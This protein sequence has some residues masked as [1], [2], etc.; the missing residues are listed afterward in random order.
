MSK[1]NA[2]RIINLNYNNNAICISDETFQ[3]GGQSTLLSLRNGG[4][5]SVLVQMMTAPFVHKQYRKTKDRPFESYFTT[6]KPTFILVEWA[7]DQGAG[8]CL[9]GMMVRKSQVSEEQ[10]AEP[11]EI[12]NFISE[13]SSRCEQDIYNLPVVEKSKKEIVLK[14]FAVCKQL[15]E[16]YKRDNSVKFYYYDMNNYAQSRQ[17]FDKLTEYRIYYKEWENIIKKI[18][19][20]E[21]GLSELFVDCK[22][23]KDLVAEWFLPAV[24]SKL[25]LERNRIKEFQNII[26]K[27]VTMYKDNKSKIE[28]RDT[29]LKFK[30]DMIGVEEHALSYQEKEKSVHGMENRIACFTK[31]LY[32]L[33]ELVRQD[34]QGIEEKK[35]ECEEKI[36][37]L[38]YEKLSMEVHVLEEELKKRNSNRNLLG[39]ERDSLEEELAKIEH[40]IHLFECARQQEI[41]EECRK[42][43][44]LLTEKAEVLKQSEEELEPERRKIGGTLKQYYR[45]QL[46]ENHKTEAAV[47]EQRQDEEKKLSVQRQNEAAYA[48]RLEELLVALTEC[49]VM[50][51][52]FNEKEE[53]YNK[54]YREGLTRNVV[55]DYEAG[56]LEIKKA[57]YQKQQE[58][59]NRSCTSNI[60]RHKEAEEQK[61]GCDRT[62]EDKRD[63]LLSQAYA[64]KNME[65][66]EEEL[67][68]QVEERRIIMRYLELEESRLWQ[69]EQL[70]EASERKLAEIDRYRKEMEQELYVLKKEWK[71]LTSGEVLE[72]P[73]EFKEL[74]QELEL[75][76]VIGMKW[77]DN[78]GYPAEENKRLVRKQPFLPYSLIL[79]RTEIKKLEQQGKEVYTSFPIPLIAREAL[80]EA[81]IE[82]KGGVIQL[83]DI[84]FYLWFNEKLLDEEALRA[85]VVQKEAEINKKEAQITKRKEEYEEYLGRKNSLIKQTVTKELLERN[86][87]AQEEGR[88]AQNALE[89]EIQKLQ[90]NRSELESEINNLLQ[91]IQKQRQDLDRC[92]RRDEDFELFCKAYEVYVEQRGAEE[93]MVN[94]KKRAEEARERAKALAASL[95]EAIT[96][97]DAKLH[98][99]KRCK[100]KLQDSYARYEDFAVSEN[101][102][103]ISVEEVQQAE[104]RY[105]AITTQMS[106]ELQELERQKERQRTQLEKTVKELN[107]LQEK[108]S[109]KEGAWQ[110]VT[111][112]EKECRHQEILQEDRIKKIE[113]KKNAWNEEDKQIGIVSSRISDKKKGIL[114][115]C[116]EE[117]PLEKSE[118]YT[119]DFDAGKNQL[120]Y[121]KKELGKE[122]RKIEKR[123][124]SLKSQLDTISEYADFE[125]KEPLVWEE[126]FL[127]MEEETLRNFTGI[128]RRDYRHETENLKKERS[129]LENVLHSLLRA[130]RYQED[131]YRKPLE[132]MLSVTENAGMVLEQLGTTVKSYNS[133]MEKLAVD[134]EMVEKEKA[135]LE[136]LLE[137][138]VKEV[139]NNLTQIDSNST[140]TVRERPIKMLR[141]QLPDWEE[142][143]GLYKQ[144]LDDYMSEL[145]RTGVEIYERNENAADYFGTRITTKSLYDAV[146]GIGNIQIR[147][148]KIE[149]QREYPITWAEVAKNSGGEGFLSAFV[150]LASLLHYMRRDATDIFADR[151]EGKVLVMDNP[152]AQTNAA[153][154]LKPLMDMAKKMNTQL[155]CLS[156]LGGDSI[157]RR[158]DNIYVLNL[159]S[160]S[161]RNGMMYLRGEHKRGAE[162]ETIVTSQVEVLE[163]MTLF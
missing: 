53:E 116:G 158:F 84:S 111:Y 82:K 124:N 79:P 62:I 112:S 91:I 148:Y 146:I 87:T 77:L 107:R 30:E 47:C 20:K 119:V 49:Q 130:E 11:L 19:L 131:Y 36:A 78:N 66:E 54:K 34:L 42:E 55:G 133:Q 58:E 31:E 160:A 6:A 114:E 156:G 65:K 93:H 151:N 85:L 56:C 136:G 105:E 97:L 118:I 140:I 98:E 63:E 127:Q 163:Q 115:Q 39:F 52:S 108:Y 51:K 15:F 25:N 4:G 68:E 106:M 69:K 37:R 161:L 94:E 26:G 143:E 125:V 74:L 71:Q 8:Y 153:H 28:R 9:T 123:L 67:K 75:H 147:L 144:R 48:K 99:I 10:S 61:R 27:Y 24:E 109:L 150:V 46:E 1:I 100:E 101:S 137:D 103:L 129:R 154:L 102:M 33:E 132:A 44:W 3:M 41:V 72:L 35:Q 110:E 81:S 38:I 16:S 80:E 2:V 18:N 76:P 64:L 117:K 142:N 122:G 128:M 57:E 7:L 73:E 149:E 90:E 32:R 120:E 50:I 22:N 162:E 138:Y 45:K 21:S 60:K 83:P 135:R 88:A 86:R 5:K 12:V 145:T 14:N 152:F 134:I 23:E 40:R 29:I 139:H 17:Y 157:Y 70:L 96:S 155:I 159:V 89:N 59:I 121:L 95:E 13:Y 104:A 92:R 141:L 113:L 126:D 43:L